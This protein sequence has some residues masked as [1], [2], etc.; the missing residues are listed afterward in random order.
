M[1][2]EPIA[3][4]DDCGRQYGHAHGFP[5]LIMQSLTDA[6]MEVIW[7]RSDGV[8]VKSIAFYSYRCGPFGEWWMGDKP[9]SEIDGKIMSV[10]TVSEERDP[11]YSSGNVGNSTTAPALVFDVVGRESDT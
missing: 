3:V 5:D 6:V 1:T 10:G 9:L 11:I 2:D 7:L 8:K 4:C